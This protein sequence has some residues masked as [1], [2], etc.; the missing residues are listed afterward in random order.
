[1]RLTFLTLLVCTSIH[2]SSQTTILI[3]NDYATI[4][5]GLDAA[6]Q[7]DTVLV[8]AGTY[9]ESVVW[10]KTLSH[11]SLIGKSGPS[12]TIIDGSTSL[13]S[14]HILIVEDLDTG[15]DQ[16]SRIE[17]FTFKN[18]KWGGVFID[19]SQPLLKNLIIENNRITDSDIATGPGLYLHR[20]DGLV[21][22]CLFRNNEIN[23]IGNASGGGLRA[24]YS[25]LI[26]DN[27]TF[28]KNIVNGTESSVGAGM[29]F[30]HSFSTHSLRMK[31]CTFFDNKAFGFKPQGSALFI[32][33][34]N[35]VEISNTVFLKNF[36]EAHDEACAIRF[37]NAWVS[38]NHCTVFGNNYGIRLRESKLNAVNS[39]FYSNG[40]LEIDQGDFPDLNEVEINYS[41]VEG[42][43][44]GNGIITGEPDFVN[45]G[46]VIPNKNSICVNAANTN[47]S[48]PIDRIG[49]L[50][51][52]PA[53]T[54]PDIGAY[55]IDQESQAALVK[56]FLDKNED[57]NQD[58]D[59]P[60]L[61]VGSLLHN[62]IVE[63]ENLSEE[64]IY[65]SLDIGQNT[66]SWNGT[67][68]GLWINTGPS[69]VELSVPDDDFFETILFGIVSVR[70]IKNLTP[71][72]YSPL[73]VCDREITMDFI[74]RNN[75]TRLETGL[76]S[77]VLDSIMED[78]MALETPDIEDGFNLAWNFTDLAPGAI[79]KR[80]VRITVP[81]FSFAQLTDEYA[82]T[83][84]ITT[85]DQPGYKQDYIY[86]DMIRC[87]Y[88]PNDKLVNPQ[89]DDNLALIDSDLVYT[90]RFQNVGN[91]YAE[92]VLVADTL[93]SNLDMSTF[94][95]LSTSH[96][97]KLSLSIEEYIVHF[98]FNDIFLPDSTT[99]FEGSNGYVMYSIR[100]DS[101]VAE[102]TLVE[103][104]AHIYFD[105][106]EA[107]ITN[108][109]E[110]IMVSEFPVLDATND[111]E[112]LDITVYPNPSDSKF[113]FSEEIDEF[114][115]FD[116]KGIQIKIREDVREI[117]LEHYLPGF[118]YAKIKQG[119]KS[120]LL[121]LV[122]I[123]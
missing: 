43:Y 37:R 22:N 53:N 102:N 2:L 59:E 29:S 25:N 63:Y 58:P 117:S 28:E 10:P 103:N 84:E 44:T 26:L 78:F 17:G 100:A 77:I 90:I 30:A 1:M 67:N 70:D 19:N 12:N 118:Y 5:E 104:T 60:F 112:L 41:L 20:F 46:S 47:T 72:I 73:F 51:P 11:A 79:F 50:R 97:E 119:E 15:L 66:I 21:I 99:N 105:F 114:V 81:P 76:M 120:G 64:G 3:P 106:N 98:D 23:T 61:G 93:N 8:S 62:G 40:G 71:G 49:N 123:N 55:E 111:E 83:V 9:F 6:E 115:L 113:Y 31:N 36:A 108:T 69:N 75:G 39:I 92:D 33:E 45:S 34:I 13:D 65:V 116:S 7:G 121:K 109:T 94:R 74:I 86:I 91:Y 96:R 80:Q 4:Q 88:D 16:D 38:M 122:L 42:G 89:R 48:L 32:A 107:I 82:F 87:A 56:F 52:L 85:P 68:S 101:T 27:C 57:G 35:D 54:R 18:G 110:N 24:S 95:L 14:N